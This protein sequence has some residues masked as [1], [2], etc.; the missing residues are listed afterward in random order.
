MKTR[1]TIW[2]AIIAIAIISGVI[3]LVLFTF[4]H[5]VPPHGHTYT[6]M[7]VCKRRVLR[8]AQKHNKLPSSLQ[9]TQPIEN[10]ITSIEDGWGELLDYSVDA[11]GIVKFI[12]F[13]KDKKPGGTGK[14]M[15]II[16]TFPSKQPDGSWSNELVDITF[17]VNSDPEG[18]RMYNPFKEGPKLINLNGSRTI[19]GL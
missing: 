18:R 1:N 15:D 19:R 13:G 6:S 12:S 3:V 4:V 10:Y 8:Y 16:G 9:D 11:N 7:T 5:F 17:Q 2:I 14:N